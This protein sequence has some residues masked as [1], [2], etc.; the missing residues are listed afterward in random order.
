MLERFLNALSCIDQCFI[1]DGLLEQLPQAGWLGKTRVGGIDLN[2]AR[3]RWVSQAVVIL[4][5]SGSSFTA[6][7]L[8]T[9]VQLLSNQPG[10]YCVRRAAYDLKKLRAKELVERIA[11]TRNYQATPQGLK[12]MVA[13]GVLRTKVIQPLLAAAQQLRPSRGAQNPTPIDLHYQTMR[14]TMRSIFQELGLAA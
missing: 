7:Q 3:M 9:Q 8:A 1:A 2:K 6:A 4:T 13:L 5:S 11:Q 14:T 10:A 12:A